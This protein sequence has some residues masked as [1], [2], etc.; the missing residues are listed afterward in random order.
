VDLVRQGAVYG[1]HLIQADKARNAAVF[2][3]ALSQ[4]F[5]TGIR[6]YYGEILALLESDDHLNEEQRQFVRLELRC[7]P[8]KPPRQ[9]ESTLDE[10]FARVRSFRGSRPYFD[11]LQFVAKLKE[12]APFNN[13]LVFLQRPQ[14]IYFASAVDWAKRYKR[15]VKEEAIPIVI[16]QPRGPIMLVYEV[17]D[18]VG[19]DL[20]AHVLNPFAVAGE[21]QA[22]WQEG[23]LTD[24]E[25]AGI[26]VVGARLGG[27]L[28]GVAIRKAKQV[29]FVVEI[30]RDQ[31]PAERFVTLCHELAHIYLG[32]LG[33]GDR[34]GWPSRIG[35]RR[36]VTKLEA[37]SVAHLVA[38]RLG[39]ETLSVEYLADHAARPED[40]ND[41]SLEMVTKVA[42]RLERAAG[43]DR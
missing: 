15:Q 4:M 23:L 8:L 16:L 26:S 37:E 38:T 9:H 24:A 42:G 5:G 20:P 19:P 6:L 14:A 39:L 27:R 29:Q 3:D 21:Y 41:V 17:A 12:Y 11:A 2:L 30:N 43:R 22:K 1:S 33:P 40:F 36:S 35:L 25:S 7:D 10:L 32:H 31:K 28:A 13:M 18:T 34:T